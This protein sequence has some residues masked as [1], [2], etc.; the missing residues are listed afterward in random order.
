M[1][2]IQIAFA[3]LFASCVSA[4]ITSEIPQ[5]IRG[6]T[7]WFT[8]DS[9]QSEKGKE[10]NFKTPTPPPL[11]PNEALKIARKAISENRISDIEWEIFSIAID[12]SKGEIN[13]KKTTYTYYL[14]DLMESIDFESEEFKKRIAEGNTQ[15]AQLKIMITMD[16][17]AIIP[18]KKD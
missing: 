12:Q 15:V 11:L 16:G 17:D 1:K 9:G 5:E 7:Y 3:I 13:G 10:W 18:K 14:V 4:S 8:I 6:D 2:Y